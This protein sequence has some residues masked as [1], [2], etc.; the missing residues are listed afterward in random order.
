ME[1]RMK[2]HIIPVFVP[3]YGCPHQCVFCNQHKITGSDAMMTAE[4]AKDIIEEA[5]S[6]Q[7]RSAEK[8]VAFYGGSFTA[9]PLEKQRELLSV[10]SPLYEDGIIHSVR[11]STRPDAIDDVILENLQKHH[12]STIELGVQSMDD[13]VLRASNRGHTSDDVRAAVKVIRRYPFMLGLQIMPGLPSEDMYSLLRTANAVRE[14]APDFV[15]IYPTV[16]IDDTP[17]A[18]AYKCGKYTPLTLQEAV[19]RTAFLKL[20]F[21][22]AGIPVIRMGLQATAELDRDGTVLAGPYHPAFGELVEAELFR[23]MLV[24]VLDDEAIVGRCLT[25]HHHPS[26]AS[27]VRGQKRANLIWLEERYQTAQITCTADGKKRGEL[28]LDWGNGQRVINVSMT[29]MI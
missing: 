18:D 25:I 6:W 4:Y 8:E 24:H 21:E 5:L 1:K 17:L 7:T 9:I 14:L 11:L 26:D 12:V 3:H 27:K 19:T 20:F 29:D 16:V 23:Q 28:V 15:R 2:R 13:A 10:V 22:R